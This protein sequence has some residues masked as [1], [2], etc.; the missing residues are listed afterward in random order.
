[1]SRVIHFHHRRPQQPVTP[2]TRLEDIDRHVVAKS[3]WQRPIV[4]Y[5]IAIA[6]VLLIALVELARAGGPQYVAGIS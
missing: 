3:W 1:M 6:L 2:P 4:I 5:G